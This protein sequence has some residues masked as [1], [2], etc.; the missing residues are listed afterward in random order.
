MKS[1][2]KKN[3]ARNFFLNFVLNLSNNLFREP[4][5]LL[6]NMIGHRVNGDVSNR[7]MTHRRLYG[8]IAFIVT[9]ADAILF[10]YHTFHQ[11][12]GDHW[13]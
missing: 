8:G 11:G 5:N 1:A 7:I 4:P 3:G 2:I 6:N 10:H 13:K 9:G 12:A